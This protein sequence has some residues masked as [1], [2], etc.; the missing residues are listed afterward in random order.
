MDIPLL[1]NVFKS[2]L[3]NIKLL[4][5]LSMLAAA[6]IL[7]FNILSLSTYTPVIYGDGIPEDQACEDIMDCVLVVYT[8]GAIGDDMDTLVWG[9]FLFDMVYVVFMELLFA[10]LISGIMLD[11][12]A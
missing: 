8:S 4:T 7:V 9:R 5:M 3:M 2:I 11:A 1:T 10:N 6:F 12:F